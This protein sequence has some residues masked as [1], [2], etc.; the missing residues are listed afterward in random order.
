LEE[1]L[2]QALKIYHE[3]NF[4]VQYLAEPENQNAAK[5]TGNIITFLQWVIVALPIFITFFIGILNHL[6]H[7]KK[8]ISLRSSAE[9]I[10]SEIFRYRTKTGIYS[11]NDRETK[12]ADKAQ[13]LNNHLMQTEVKLSAL[14]NYTDRLPPPYIVRFLSNYPF[15]CGRRKSI[16]KSNQAEVEVN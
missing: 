1:M 2:K 3:S 10:K 4:F 15:L 9:N 12:M 6:S 11:D 7:G 8:W 14:K 13:E 5:I 16:G